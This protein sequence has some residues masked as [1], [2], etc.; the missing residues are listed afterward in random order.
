MAV[1][2]LALG[3]VPALR[4]PSPRLEPPSI[5]VA[6]AAVDGLLAEAERHFAQRPDAREVSLAARAFE[7]AARGDLTRVEG[8]LGVA[9]VASWQVEHERDS[10]AR[11]ALVDVALEAAQWCSRRAPGRAECD[12]ALG[13]ALGQQARERP[14]TAHDG[15]GKMVEALR[16]VIA[17]KPGLDDAGP[18]RVLALVLL[19]APGWPAGPGDAEE[20][21][22]QAGK[23]IAL[24]PGHPENQLAW[25]EALAKVGRQPES[26]AAAQRALALARARPSD[27]DASEWAA[28]AE[29]ALRDRP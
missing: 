10:Q 23:A 27:P 19:R 5:P 6:A 11:L 9:R 28:R 26:T 15:L 20:G 21:L 8:L 24:A 7:D 29:R 12:Y 4:E 17:T 16:R 22:A 25:A 1:G 18:H 3:C 14:S 13:Q 2:A